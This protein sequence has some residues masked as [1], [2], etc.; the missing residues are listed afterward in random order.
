MRVGHAHSLLGNPD[1][2]LMD[3]PTNDID[4]ETNLRLERF[5]GEYP[6]AVLMTCHD[7]DIRN[8][9]FYRIVEIDSA[10]FST[11]TGD[12]D[13]Y[14]RS[15]AIADADREAA[16]ARQQAMRA[17]ERRFIERFQAH[18]AKAAQV[19]SRVKK[20]EKIE[21]VELPR[22]RKVVEFR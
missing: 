1:V 19:Q 3:E 12:Y 21:M 15:R 18:A 6:G 16:H 20:L 7:I 2:L 9:I 17:K 8:S 5:I 22:R 14:V 11:Y 4:I 13:F 10:E